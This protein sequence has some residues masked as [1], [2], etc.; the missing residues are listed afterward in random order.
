MEMQRA[1]LAEIEGFLD[2]HGMAETTFGLR[3]VNDGKFMRRLR[4]NKNMTIATIERVRTF[5]RDNDD[6]PSTTPTSKRRAS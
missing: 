4:N 1:L 2:R 6:W 3:A 5:I